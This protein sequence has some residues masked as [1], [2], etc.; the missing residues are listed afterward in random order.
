MLVL[1]QTW[2]LSKCAVNT[3]WNCNWSVLF[4]HFFSSFI[5][6]FDE[7]L[8]D[9][10]EAL[11]VAPPNNRDV[12]RVLLRLRDDIRQAVSPSGN[13]CASLLGASVDTLADPET[14]L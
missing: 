10:Q 4:L 11:R 7:A 13:S 6:L 2:I 3:F 14:R 5:R 8:I 12:R 9:A 1:K